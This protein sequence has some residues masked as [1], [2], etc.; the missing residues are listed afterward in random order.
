MLTYI[1]QSSISHLNRLYTER[2][3]S[4]CTNLIW[5]RNFLPQPP[6]NP[7]DRLFVSRNFDQRRAALDQDSV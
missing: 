2:M 5:G 3:L 4:L 6:M 1:K 7:D